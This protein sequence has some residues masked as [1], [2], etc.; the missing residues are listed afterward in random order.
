MPHGD[1]HDGHGDRQV[2][3]EDQAP[4]HGADQPSADE[5]ADRRG[6]AAETRPGAD[7]PAT[8]RPG[9]GRLQDGQAARGQQRG[10][11]RPAGPGPGSATSRSAPART[12]AT[13]RANQ[14]MPITKTRAP[15]VAG[16]PA[17]RRAAATR[18][19][20]GCTPSTT[21]CR[22]AT[23]TWK[24]RPIGGSAMPTTVASRAAMP[25]P[26][27]VADQHPAPGPA[28]VTEPRRPGGGPG[29]GASHQRRSAA[30]QWQDRR[31]S[32]P[33]YAARPARR[34][35][36][37][38]PCSAAAADP[39]GAAIV[40]AAPIA[41]MAMMAADWGRIGRRGSPRAPRQGMMLSGDRP[42]ALRSSPGP[43]GQQRAAGPGTGTRWGRASHKEMAM[44]ESSFVPLPG[45][46][47]E[48]L[49]GA[50]RH[51]ACR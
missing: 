9:E 13:P 42:H 30:G 36:A 47:R 39:G 2:D 34:L 21:H 45:S 7:G 28:G 12:A 25:E 11:R 48:T 24:S 50:Q 35:A 29:R 32:Q 23:P 41:V 49:S 4:R 3:E 44:T 33:Q 31:R 8:G 20:S 38:Q 19:G 1:G 26:S 18:P 5:R 46:E 16:R 51:R 15:P 17:T 40:P 22:L 6:Q 27:T 14:T 10:A 37:R 43:H